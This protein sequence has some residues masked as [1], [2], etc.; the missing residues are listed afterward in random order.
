MQ[1]DRIFS[2][3]PFQVVQWLAAGEQ[4][5]FGQRFQPADAAAALAEQG[6]VVGRANAEP[7]A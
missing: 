1:H 6:L 5:V 4:I 7:E 2:A 3:Q